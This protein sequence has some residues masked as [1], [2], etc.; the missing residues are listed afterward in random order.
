[1]TERPLALITGAS[2]GI[3]ATIALAL[4]N[5]HSLLLGGRDTEALDAV[6]EHLPDARPWPVELTDDAAVAKAAADIDR[7]DVLV[8]SAG[9]ARVAPLTESPAD[10]W[11]SMYEIN[12]VAVAELT[13]LLL[14]ALRAAKGHVVLINSGAGQNANPNWGP[15]A[16][17]KFALRAYADVLRAEEES[18]GLR[19]TSVYPGRTATDMQR[20]VRADEGADFEPERYLTPE[21]VAELVRTAIAATPDAHPTDL[22][23]RSRPVR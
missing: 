9:V 23:I 16:A 12:V 22:V 6:A 13:R 7:L 3:G 18:A 21:S 11:R 5:T 10:L 8:H 15:Y 17:S 19:V 14:P 1:M 20:I 2:R 4:G